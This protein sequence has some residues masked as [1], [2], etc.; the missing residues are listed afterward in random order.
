MKKYIILTPNITNIGGAQI[1]VRNKKVFLE[2]NGWEVDIYSI[3]E[4]QILIKDI[5]VFKDNIIEE[6]LYLPFFYSK[7]E[8]L[9]IISRLTEKN[10]YDNLIIE[11]NTITLALW[12]EMIAKETNGKH[13]IY[14]LNEHFENFSKTIFLFLDFKHK[15]KEL[16][17]IHNKSLELLFKDYKRIAENEKYSLR[18]TCANAVVDV[19]NYIID[20][21]KK[22]D[23]NIGCIS[24]L[25]KPFV[26]TMVDEI[27]QFTK[28]NSSKTIQLVLVGESPDHSVERSI[29]KKTEDV[30]NLNLVM[31]G[32]LFPI[33]KKLFQMMDI[34]IGV[35]G[36]AGVSAN[37]NVLTL[38][39]DVN[40]H[41]PIGLL[42]YDTRD[43]IYSQHATDISISAALERILI[44]EQMQN[45]EIEI[46]YKI[47]DFRKEYLNH[48]DFIYSSNQEKIFYEINGIKLN[49]KELI[50][51]YL[52][53]VAGIN[54]FEALI[55]CK[56]KLNL[57]LRVHSDE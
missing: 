34:F 42:G 54:N 48:L 29:I 47:V 26:S 56:S 31:T 19:P 43:S 27:I 2:E 14:L 5:A 9:N 52:I 30:Q 53:K 13:I 46:D 32:R 51:K 24:R 18:A 15:R 20:N 39:V 37:E 21:I 16:A 36:A 50:K 44:I 49:T 17:G 7:N 41:K 38:T 33:P 22:K 10:N 23:I 45:E 12:G 55:R 1:Y 3:F 8:R 40:S 11:S 6:L 35:A 4:G 25:E 28:I 57:I